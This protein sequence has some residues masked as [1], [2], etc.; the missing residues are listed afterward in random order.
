MAVKYVREDYKGRARGGLGTYQRDLASGRTAKQRLTLV[1]LGLALFSVLIL[2]AHFLGL[3]TSLR[4]MPETEGS[5]VVIEKIVVD[6]DTPNPSYFLELRVEIESTEANQADTAGPDGERVPSAFTLEDKV[7]VTEESWKLVETGT[8]LD[9]TYQ[10]TLDQSSLIVR[11]LKLNDPS[12][13]GAGRVCRICTRPRPKD[14]VATNP[15]FSI[16]IA[17][18]CAVSACGL[19]M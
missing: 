14:S 7:S 13:A 16:Y 6:S 9:V 1:Y 11:S 10:M 15:G 2:V 3:S 17:I 19:R 5:A 18:S 12:T 4:L 8:S